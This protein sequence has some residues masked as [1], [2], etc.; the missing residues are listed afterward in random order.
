MNYK[1]NSDF[2]QLRNEF[3]SSFNK[4]NPIEILHEFLNTL[5]FAAAI[6][7]PDRKAIFS[8]EV[9][10]NTMGFNSIE[11][12]LNKRPGEIISC[13]H[14]I[15]NQNQCGIS[16][17]CKVCGA[18][19]AMTKTMHSR[20]IT[21]SEMRAT[22]VKNGHHYTY[23]FQ[24][25]V[26]PLILNDIVFMIL[27]LNDISHEKRRKALEK[28]FFHDVLNKISSLNGLLE[29][30]QKQNAMGS[31]P[32]HMNLMSTIL[33]DLTEEIVA[34]RE[35]VAAENGELKVRKELVVIPKLIRRVIDQ[36]EQFSNPNEI[37][38]EFEPENEDLT[39]ISDRILINR[40]ITNL[41]KNAM[42]ASLPYQIV[43]IKSVFKDNKALISVHNKTH[44]SEENQLQIFQ[45]SFSTK[46]P[47]RGLGTYS[48]KLL[49][50]RYLK[51]KVYFTSNNDLGTTFTVELPIK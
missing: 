41:L 20:M 16:D 14:A 45:R 13:L 24:V 39:I 27:Y 36:A 40:I 28:I 25:I 43:S 42:E 19:N 6:L 1:Q 5:P 2:E 44:I 33:G 50:E 4:S 37:V 18:L 34:Q 51:G 35:L 3:V 30:L 38:I 49:T 47:N 17:S 8:N 12:V 7:T 29:I 23:D 22:T 46:S 26:T 32:E 31:S 11:E 15:E 48:I 9:L 21:R 10:L